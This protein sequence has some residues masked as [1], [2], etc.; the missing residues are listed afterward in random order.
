MVRYR[1]LVNSAF[2][3]M[4][5]VEMRIASLAIAKLAVI[6]AGKS[7]FV[8]ITAQ[9]LAMLGGDSKSSYAQ[10]EKATDDLLKRIVVFRNLDNEDAKALNLVD[11]EG[12][13]VE[14]M[15]GEYKAPWFIGGNYNNKK[16]YIGLTFNPNLL[17]LFI[18]LKAEFTRYSLSDLKGLSSTYPI[19]L[20][21][22]LM[23]Y[24]DTGFFDVAVDELRERLI[25]HDKNILT[26][27][28]DFKRRVIVFSVDQINKSTNTKIHV[29]FTEKKV[30]RKVERILF[31][32][33]L[34][35]NS[36]Q[37]GTLDFDGTGNII[38]GEAEWVGAASNV[39]PLSR[40]TLT[41][42]QRETFGDWLAG[43]NIK[44][45]DEVGYEPSLFVNF[46]YKNEL[47]K[48]GLFSNCT[49]EEISAKMAKLLES[50]YFV[51]AIYKPWLTQFGVKIGA[52]RSRTKKIE[53]E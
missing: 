5:L 28:A 42:K 41:E 7:T 9:E 32:F 24:Q 13:N 26:T 17:P 33:K 16:G 45:N 11:E 14:T 44:K 29:V 2:L 12:R 49:N 53:E 8:K 50:P 22:M 34:R 48:Y 51:K 25:P 39:S 20:Y 31:T 52:R 1:N 46:L 4:S 18:E 27:Y 36:P 43:K 10:M 40:F 23:Q 30:A 3:P 47:C 21:G 37:Q 15:E 19:R 6:R 35:K 38:E